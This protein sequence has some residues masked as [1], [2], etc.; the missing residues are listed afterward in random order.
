MNSL[1]L[2]LQGKK[3]YLVVIAASV[4]LFGSWQ[5]WWIIPD[6]IYQGLMALAVLFLRNGFQRQVT[7]LHDHIEEATGVSKPAACRSEPDGRS[8]GATTGPGAT[9][10]LAFA[11]LGIG[12]ALGAA[13]LFAGCGTAK[14]EQGGAYAP[15][16]TNEDGTVSAA[17]MP[18]YGFFITDSAFSLA[19]A[20]MDGAFTFERNNRA[21]LWQ[22]SPDIKHGLDK[23]RPQAY[24]VSLKYSLARQQYLL[25]PVPAGLTTLQTILEETQ[26]LSESVLAALPNQTATK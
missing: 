11:C 16:V 7:D 20:A 26:R 19:Y 14:L 3:T 5:H 23:F 2:A 4:L 13:V 1:L 18:D 12:A 24:A 15:A 6:Q 17:A 22:I 25:H 21:M 9:L 8:S 10:P